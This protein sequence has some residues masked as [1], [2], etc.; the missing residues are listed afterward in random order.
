MKSSIES[1]ADEFSRNLDLM[2]ED[3]LASLADAIG[4]ETMMRTLLQH[5]A[6]RLEGKFGVDHPRV[7]GLNVRL[8]TNLELI[9]ALNVERE[10]YAVDVPEVPEDSTLVHGRIVDENQRGIRR[11]IVCLVDWQSSPVND[12]ADSVTDGSGYYAVSL[13]ADSVERIRKE[14]PNG[15][16]LAVLTQRG[17]LLHRERKPRVLEKGARTLVEISFDRRTRIQVEDPGEPPGEGEPDDETD[18]VPEKVKVP[19]VVGIKLDSAKR[20]I[21]KYR[22]AVGKISY[23]VSPDIGVVLAQEPKEGME[24]LIGSSVD[25]VVGEKARDG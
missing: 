2:K 15:V 16:F 12:A 17:E 25:L 24:A 3:R 4:I 14:N 8:K 20:K 23:R 10:V 22:F 21:K 6:I 1:A 19:D 7:E 18:A 11:L 13:N 9:N 5:E